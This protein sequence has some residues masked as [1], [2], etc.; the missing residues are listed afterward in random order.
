MSTNTEAK[1]V[2]EINLDFMADSAAEILEVQ[3]GVRRED[4][5]FGVYKMKIAN[6][7]EFKTSK[8]E[9]ML[10]IDID[11]GFE[12]KEGKPR[13][14]SILMWYNGVY[15][16]GK[17]RSERLIQLY[18]RISGKDEMKKVSD[19]KNL[20]GIPFA[21]ATM[22]S[23]S[24]YFQFWYA[25]NIKNLERM[26]ASYK[27]KDMYNPNS[28]AVKSRVNQFQTTAESSEPMPIDDLPF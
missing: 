13:L 12:T 4:L 11:T 17:S 21:V 22:K 3:K 1:Q 23:E 5:G 6:L 8:D 9:S 18:K 2:T 27:P 10:K 28:E 14:F 25:D 26:Q 20:V 24:G 16:D 15:A 19:M 7:S